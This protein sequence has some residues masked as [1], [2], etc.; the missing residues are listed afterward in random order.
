MYV[1]NVGDTTPS[2]NVAPSPQAPTGTF[3]PA[4]GSTAGNVNVVDQDGDSLRYYLLYPP[5]YG[6]VT[7]NAQTGDYVYTPYLTDDGYNQPYQD[8]FQVVV[9]DGNYVTTANVPVQTFVDPYMFAW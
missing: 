1:V 3:D 6:A 7:L 9:T 4:T 5:S 8:G 2:N